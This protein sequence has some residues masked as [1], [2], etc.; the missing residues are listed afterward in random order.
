MRFKGRSSSKIYCLQLEVDVDVGGYVVRQAAAV[1]L[2]QHPQEDVRGHML[3][4]PQ[5]LVE[6]LVDDAQQRL[7]PVG[8]FIG[9]HRALDHVPQKIGVFLG[10][11]GDLPPAQ[12]LYVELDALVGVVEHLFYPGDDP[13]LVQVVPH[14]LVLRQVHLGHQEDQP[15]LGDGLGHGQHRFFPGHLEL[16]HHPGEEYQAPHGQHRQHQVGLQFPAIFCKHVLP[17]FLTAGR[18]GERHP[19]KSERLGPAACRLQP[20]RW[21]ALFMIRNLSGPA[22]S[23][24]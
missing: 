17:S 22:A 1:L 6:L 15:V 9:E 16:Q 4:Q 2:L 5:V 24:V 21:C 23:A 3:E 7:R 11:G 14:R 19:H 10:Q 12:A 8:L 13:D 20:F 18:P